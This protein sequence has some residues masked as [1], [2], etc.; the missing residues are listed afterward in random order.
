[1][2]PISPRDTADV[3]RAVSGSPYPPEHFRGR[4]D[5]NECQTG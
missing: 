2:R 5:I 1:M 4:D 3:D